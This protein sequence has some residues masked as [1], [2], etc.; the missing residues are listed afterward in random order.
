MQVANDNSLCSIPT[1]SVFN[2]LL[3][4]STFTTTCQRLPL[5]PGHPTDW[6][7]LYTALKIVQR[8]NVSVG[9]NQKTIITL[10][11][12]LY[13]KCMQLRVKKDMYDNYIFQLGELHIVFAFLKAMGKYIAGSGLDQVLT[14]SEY[15]DQQH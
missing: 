14:E 8:I 9:G 1:W 13:A 7:N 12:Q 3:T 4:K 11:L 10:D 15:M 6:G 5:Y 2:S